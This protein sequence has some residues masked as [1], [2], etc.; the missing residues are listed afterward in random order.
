M[1]GKLVLIGRRAKGE[2]GRG[3]NWEGFVE[4]RRQGG[5]EGGVV[6]GRGGGV[7]S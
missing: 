1:D 4:A 7:Y 6:C 2:P 3:A 5:E